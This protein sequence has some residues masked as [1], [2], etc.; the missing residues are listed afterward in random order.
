[1]IRF[2]VILSCCLLAIAP[3]TAV[4]SDRPHFTDY[5]VSEIFHGPPAPVQL[6]T[7]EARR[8]RTELQ[9]HTSR[10]PDFAGHYTIALIGC[11]S[12]CSVG[13]I[14]DSRTGQVWFPGL[15]VYSI[16]DTALLTGP[17]Y[18]LDSELIVMRGQ[19]NDI[20]KGIAYYRWHEN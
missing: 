15:H 17:E 5:P 9:R 13:A 16:S 6:T 12:T 19:I 3:Q 4:R 20:Y 7:P 14:V 11:G 18:R 8:V 1:M 10:P 2:A